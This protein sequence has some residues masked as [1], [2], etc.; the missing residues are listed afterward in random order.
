MIKIKQIFF[1]FISG[2]NTLSWP[3]KIKID[4]WYIDHW[5]IWLDLKILLKTIWVVIFSRKGI[6]EDNPKVNLPDDNE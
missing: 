5:S 3:E 6:Y 4:I 2:Y 1:F